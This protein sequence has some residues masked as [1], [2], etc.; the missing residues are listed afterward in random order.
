MY[1]LHDITGDDII[2]WGL[3][4]IEIN[5]RSV[6]TN[7][8]RIV[9]KAYNS[10]KEMDLL[11]TSDDEKQVMILSSIPKLGLLIVGKGGCTWVKETI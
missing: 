10:K 3:I 9:R 5:V 2:G 7:A 11:I 1:K 8:Y 6:Y 4:Q